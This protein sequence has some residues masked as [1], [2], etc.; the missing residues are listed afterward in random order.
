MTN[1]T[2]NVP[3]YAGKGLVLVRNKPLCNGT[4]EL[5][6]VRWQKSLDRLEFD[7]IIT[8]A[9]RR[10]KE[11]YPN[12][13]YYVDTKR[14]AWGINAYMIIVPKGEDIQNE[15]AKRTI[16]LGKLEL[17]I[18]QEYDFDKNVCNAAFSR[19]GIKANY[20]ISET[21]KINEIIDSLGF[22]V[23]PVEQ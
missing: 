15:D 1:A 17:R 6:N 18:P 5:L 11:I 19:F 20:N 12:T 9:K 7:N 3:D 22:K 10:A 2:D 13:H 23:E 21:Q 16:K 14:R 4:R 8:T